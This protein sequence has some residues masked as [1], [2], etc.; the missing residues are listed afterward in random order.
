MQKLQTSSERFF[1]DE[2]KRTCCLFCF[3]FILSIH[4]RFIK[5]LIVYRGCFFFLI[6]IH[7]N[8]FPSYGFTHHEHTERDKNHCTT[9]VHDYH[10]EAFGNIA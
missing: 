8:C 7:R 9:A 4:S 6:P 10:N 3:M 5:D 1:L 2:A